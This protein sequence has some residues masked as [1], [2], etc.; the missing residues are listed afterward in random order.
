[1]NER[2]KFVL[3][4]GFGIFFA[5]LVFCPWEVCI[6]RPGIPPLSYHPWRGESTHNWVTIYDWSPEF[7]RKEHPDVVYLERDTDRLRWQI[8]IWALAV[9]LVFLRLKT[10]SAVDQLLPSVSSAS[11]AP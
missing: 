10:D 4:V 2:Q 8:M 9:L 1:M 6:R 7:L 5:M 11:Q 3:L